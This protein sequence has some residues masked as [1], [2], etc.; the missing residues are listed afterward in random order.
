MLFLSPRKRWPIGLDIGADSIR[1]LQFCQRGGRTRVRAAER[2]HFPAPGD[3]DPAQ[4]KEMAIAAITD[5]LK[6]G[7]FRGRRVVSAL[8]CDELNIKNIRL[9]RMQVDELKQAVQWEAKERFGFDV[10]PDQLNCLNAG[11]IRQGTETRDEIIM[12][13]VTSEV[14]ENHVDL[15]RQVSLVPEAIDAEP[16][17]LF[18][19]FE[20]YLRRTADEECVTVIVDIGHSATRVI[21]ARGRR[22][23]FIKNIDIGGRRFTDAVAGQLNL[24][25]GEAHDL[26]L[27]KMRE[28]EQSPGASEFGQDVAP[29]ERER[30]SLEWSIHDAVRGEVESLAREISLCLRYC[31]VT[32]R[33]LRAKHIT[34]TGGE[35]YDRALVEL[36]T[37]QLGTPAA[38]G[39]PLRG[40]DISAVDLGANRRATV[41]EWALCSGLAFNGAF[42]A[43]D[44]AK[45][46]DDAKR[47]LS[48]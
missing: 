32:F 46:N 37:S 47:R 14:I 42:E 38:I 10:A 6:R 3:Q 27:R 43:A 11:Q 8:R 25:Y 36:L 17:A 16:V 34:L 13:A 44:T 20:R 41:T 1:M 21:V 15:L 33:G 29:H 28:H 23:V 26:R 4:R 48:A 18:R 7:R 40:V 31:S 30:S 45:E 12:L 22:I 5:M 19:S 24:T 35:T 39:E 9:P 2:W